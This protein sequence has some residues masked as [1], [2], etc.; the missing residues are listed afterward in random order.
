MAKQKNR[1]KAFK[2]GLKRKGVLKTTVAQ[3]SSAPKPAAKKTAAKQV[4]LS[5][6]EFSALPA[7]AEI[8]ANLIE[9]FYEAGFASASD[10]AN[11]SEKEVLAL[12]G[13]GP[14]TVKKLKENGVTFKAE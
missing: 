10:F 14:A 12:K 2:L 13:V 6:E 7:L 5:L 11:V 4:K 3:T 9:T 8:R 1:K